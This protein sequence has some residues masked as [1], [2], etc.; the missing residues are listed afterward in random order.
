MIKY[1]FFI[2]KKIKNKKD[3]TENKNLTELINK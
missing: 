3:N 2:A 1:Y